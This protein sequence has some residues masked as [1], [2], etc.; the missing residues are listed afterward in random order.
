MELQY[1]FNTW[2]I[3]LF[4]VNALLALIIYYKSSQR[5]RLMKIAAFI[6]N[7]VACS[8]LSI[9]VF[10]LADLTTLSRFAMLVSIVILA[11]LYAAVFKLACQ[12][13][14]RFR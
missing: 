4:A 6:Q 12:V 3:G 10:A 2:A 14:K 11:N 7:A 5:G 13:Y 1:F 9:L 8:S